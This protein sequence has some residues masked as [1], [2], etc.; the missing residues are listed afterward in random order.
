[1]NAKDIMTTSVFSTQGN[2]KLSQIKDLFTKNKISAA[3]VLDQ[4]GEIEGIITSSDVAAIYNENLLVRNVMTHRV[5]V[6]A[7]NA[8]VKDV[9]KTMVEDKIHHIV[10]M[11]EGKVSGVISTLDVI[12]GLL[13]S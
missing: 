11:D 8:R 6:C 2:I 10:V 13:S 1:M 5:K 3:P 4:K 7:I 12:K 9:A